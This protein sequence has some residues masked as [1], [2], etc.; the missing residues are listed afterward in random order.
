M[1]TQEDTLLRGSEWGTYEGLTEDS[2]NAVL[3]GWEAFL[4]VVTLGSDLDNT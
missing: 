1:C 4:E 2:A 3:G